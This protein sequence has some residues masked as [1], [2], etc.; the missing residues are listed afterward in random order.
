MMEPACWKFPPHPTIGSLLRILNVKHWKPTQ[1]TKARLGG[2]VAIWLLVVCSARGWSTKSSRC[3]WCHSTCLMLI[4]NHRRG[5]DW[6]ESVKS[7]LS[8]SRQEKYPEKYIFFSHVCT[9]YQTS[10]CS[11][12]IS[13]PTPAWQCV[14]RDIRTTQNSERND[15]GPQEYVEKNPNPN[16]HCELPC[17]RQG[18]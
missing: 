4:I 10:H 17:A 7:T 3:Y 13:P 16:L 14:L 1:F 12:L 5:A 11:V 15:R 8:W 18:Q 6:F 9:M 2:A